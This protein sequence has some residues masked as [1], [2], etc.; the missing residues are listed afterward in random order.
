MTSGDGFPAPRVLVVHPAMAPYRIDLFNRLSEAFPFRVVFLRPI[1]A[2]DANLDARGLAESLRCD[3]GVVSPDDDPGLVRIAT[4]ML[5]EIR[6]FRPDVVV[7]HEFRHASMVMAAW[8]AIT[9]G[10]PRHVIWTTKNAREIAATDGVRR[11]GMRWL[12]RAADAVLAYSSPA[13][14]RLAEL[15]GAAIGKYFVCANHQDPARLRSLAAD[16][17]SGV[18]AECEGR[19]LGNRRLV[20][21]VS[22]LAEEKNVGV[23]ID[24]FQEAFRDAPNVVLAVIGEGPLRRALEAAVCSD[25]IVFLGQRSPA[26]VQAWMAVASLTVLASL[27]EPYGAVVGESLAHGTPV[28]CSDAAGAA[29]LIDTPRKGC[30]FSPLSVDALVEL[31]RRYGS[32]FSTVE[33]MRVRRKQSLPGPSCEDDATGFRAAMLHATLPRLPVAAHGTPFKA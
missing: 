26:E 9:G 25:R 5:K 3:Y 6:R 14:D 20:L 16:A 19:G 31:M 28:L 10:R 18:V 24:A 2:Y 11:L 13:A 1:P 23:V 15:S 7:T 4:R 27:R 33:D 29:S 12:L 21:S 17:L 32:G 22:R 30:V 8:A